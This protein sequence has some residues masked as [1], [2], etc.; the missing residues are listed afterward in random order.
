M[1]ESHGPTTHESSRRARPDIKPHSFGIPTARA[2]YSLYN[3]SKLGSHVT[4]IHKPAAWSKVSALS[5]RDT[6][7]HAAGYKKS[8]SAMLA[9]SLRQLLQLVEYSM[10]IKSR[11]L[12]ID[13]FDE[14]ANG[15][16]GYGPGRLVGGF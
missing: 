12:L 5:V 6:L 16:R 9:N 8:I 11:P 13:W 3:A 4:K 15:L 7:P 1:V 10:A 14:V 2:R